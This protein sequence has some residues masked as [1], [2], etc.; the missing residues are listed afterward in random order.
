LTDPQPYQDFAREHG[1]PPLTDIFKLNEQCFPSIRRFERNGVPRRINILC[2]FA[3][4]SDDIV[5][6]VL[7]LKDIFAT[8]EVMRDTEFNLAKP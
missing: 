8:L 1:S 6:L 3:Q 5:N 7:K 2:N 4:V